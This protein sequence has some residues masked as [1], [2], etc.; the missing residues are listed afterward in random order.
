MAA[1]AQARSDARAAVAAVAAALTRERADLEALVRRRFPAVDAGDV[2]QRA[3]VR[4]LERAGDVRDAANVEPWLRRIVVTCALDLLRERAHREVPT[5]EVPEP[6]VIAEGES[7][8]CSVSLLASLRPAYAE[9]LR[10]V[11]V[12]G[13]TLDEVAAALAID[14]GNAAVRLHRARRALRGRLREH[15]G[16]EAARECLTCAC[17]ERGCCARD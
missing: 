11:D 6:P 3:A 12:D 9:I 7:C 13:G 15:C 17:N 4:A 8:A 14:K 16:V 1:R 5:A 10:R 2:V